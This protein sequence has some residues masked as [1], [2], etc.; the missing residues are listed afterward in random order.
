VYDAIVVGL[1]AMGSAATFHLA[2][3]GRRVL[4]IDRFAPPHA[5]GSSHGQT[6]IIREAYF[7]H[8]A[9]VPL[10]QRAYMLW[11]ELE[12]ASQGK[13]FVQTR[14]L[15]I[16]RPDS[17]LVTGARRSAELHGLA[18]EILSADDVKRRFPALHPEPDMVAVLEPRA[19][20]L[21]PEACIRAHLSLAANQGAEIHTDERVVRWSASEGGVEVKTTRATYR[22][23]R[24]VISAGAWAP[25]LLADI[26]PPL[27]VE[28]QVLFWFDAARS[29]SSFAAEHCPVHL[30]EFDDRKFAYGFPDLGGGVKF[31]RH[32]HGATGSPESLPRDATTAEL[33]DIR[34]LFDR[35]LP[36]ANGAFRSSAVC[37]YTN[38]PDEN[39]WID[40]H[41]RHANVI[42]AS[43]CSGHGFKFAA[44]I[45]E[46]LANLVDG[47]DPGFDLD[48]FRTRWQAPV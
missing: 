10:V 19:G 16:G 2:R 1:G 14:G 40:R 30:W 21:L 46:V 23:G 45:G 48:L 17:M 43:P 11:D 24:L 44:A 29:A 27:T 41:P 8:P 12:R 32:H 42:I 37:F 34:R 9:Y 18:H 36:D 5:M 33:E 7:E 25:E 39:F 15:M 4:G 35:F 22:A 28:R 6:R 47:E 31:A 13:L 3:R 20:I 26:A 38:T